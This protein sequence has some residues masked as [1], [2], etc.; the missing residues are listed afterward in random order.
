MTFR[1][2]YNILDGYDLSCSTRK[3]L[4]GTRDSIVRCEVFRVIK[5]YGMWI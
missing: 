2:L 1:L 4:T 5:P 3:Q